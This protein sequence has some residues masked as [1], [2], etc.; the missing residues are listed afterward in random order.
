MRRHKRTSIRLNSCSAGIHA[1]MQ[2]AVQCP[3]KFGT[4]PACIANV[5]FKLNIYY[6]DRSHKS[7]MVR[8]IERDEMASIVFKRMDAVGAVR[9]EVASRHGPKA[10]QESLPIVVSFGC[11]C[12]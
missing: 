4:Q 8:A 3:G 6:I 7:G 5:S 9:S 1:L 11:Y 2:C 12:S 10:R